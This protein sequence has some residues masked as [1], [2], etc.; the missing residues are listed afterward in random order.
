[1]HIQV[2]LKCTIKKP[3]SNGVGSYSYVAR[4]GVP[5]QLLF[6]DKLLLLV[7][8]KPLKKRLCCPTRS[9]TK[10]L[11]GQTGMCCQLHHRAMNGQMY[12]YLVGFSKEFWNLLLINSSSLKRNKKTLLKINQNHILH[13]SK[14]YVL[15]PYV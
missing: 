11:P 12:Y 2:N 10:N 15:S 13:L 9:R 7:Y 8:K 1:M 3:N 4:Q 5:S 6:R 14:G